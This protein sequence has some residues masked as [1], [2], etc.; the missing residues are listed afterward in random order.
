MKRIIA[1]LLT[2]AFLAAG[3]MI[4]FA[5]D[6]PAEAKFEAK[7]GTVTFNHTLHQ[8]KVADCATCHHA[9]VEAGTCRSCHGVDDA[10]PKMK[11]VAHKF[12]KGCHKD[13]GGNAPTKCNMCHKK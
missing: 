7:N 5:A 10:A 9:G 6:P 8:D 13:Q 11:D 12:C 3:S 1:V 2:V 4:A